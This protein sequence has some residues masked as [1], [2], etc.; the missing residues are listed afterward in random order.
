MVV[1]NPRKDS[2]I[3]NHSNQQAVVPALLTAGAWI[4]ANWPAILAVVGT[5]AFLLVS[6]GELIGGKKSDVYK[7]MNGE[8]Q[9][10]VDS[11]K[12]DLDKAV[13]REDIPGIVKNLKELAKEY[14]TAAV[15]LGSSNPELG[16]KAKEMADGMKKLAAEAQKGRFKFSSREIGLENGNSDILLA[17]SN[18][19][20]QNKLG[21]GIKN[22]PEQD[23]LL[24]QQKLALNTLLPLP[25]VVQLI[26]RALKSLGETVLNDTSAI[27]VAEIL[28]QLKVLAPEQIQNAFEQYYQK[29]QGLSPEESISKAE[30]V[31]NEATEAS[32]SIKGGNDKQEKVSAGYSPER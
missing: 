2:D 10:K 21:L 27:K 22:V 23:Q 29:V 32:A 8:R 14:D 5:A 4:I 6:A 7:A 19:K 11:I 28:I 26:D 31:V 9:Q 25:V 17:S 18:V 1:A 30:K 13:L 12:Q 3:S 15:I 16:K 24:E 20:E